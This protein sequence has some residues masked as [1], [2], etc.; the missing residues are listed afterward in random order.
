MKWADR[1]LFLFSGFVESRVEGPECR[2]LSIRWPVAG[3]SE[4]PPEVKVAV[5]RDVPEEMRNLIEPIVTDHGLELVDVE[6]RHGRAPWHIRVIVDGPAG[7]GRVPIETCAAVSREV[8]VGLDATDLI[9]VRY[10]L[11]V[12]SPGFERT[13]A[14][15]KDF[16]AA[17]GQKVKLETRHPI[18]GRRRF[19]GELV[20][21]EDDT[22]RVQIDGETAEIPF[23][24]VAKGRVLYEFTSKD[25]SASH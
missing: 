4:W 18:D 6:R 9:P 23:A 14:R 12:S 11:E 19:R 3:S 21:F 5:Y 8:A 25:F 10:D 15:E 16:V 13:L 1:P 20:A 24:S 7:D 17:V 22:A 2:R